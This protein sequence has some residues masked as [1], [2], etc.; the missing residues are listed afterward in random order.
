M[1][2]HT[3]SLKG[4][5]ISYSATAGFIPICSK[6]TGAPEGEIFFVYYKKNEDKDVRKRP[7]TFAFN[8]GPG[9]ASMY[10]HL[11]ALGPR[12]I[13]RSSDGATLLPPPYSLHD[14]ENTL[15]DF[16]DLVFID[17]IGAG[18][19]RVVSGESRRM[20]TQSPISYFSF[21]QFTKGFFRRFSSPVKATAGCV[22]SA[23]P[24]RSRMPDF[25]RWELS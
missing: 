12:T 17:P 25:I 3:I 6:T 18:F 24:G 7:V 20:S 14:N 10:L 2:N 22:E 13:P 4:R 19:S 9:A 11:A 16:T 23:L 8:G 21:S 1:T 5:T 15:L